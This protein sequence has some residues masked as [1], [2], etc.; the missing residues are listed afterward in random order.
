MCKTYLAG[1]GGS[2]DDLGASY[3]ARQV[4]SALLACTSGELCSDAAMSDVLE[5][6]LAEAAEVVEG[7]WWFVPTGA[8]GGAAAVCEG[9]E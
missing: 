1:K 9:Q 6:E 3:A 5:T 4:P 8:D 2:V 7:A